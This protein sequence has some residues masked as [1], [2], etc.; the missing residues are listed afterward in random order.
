M[1]WF[2]HPSDLAR[3]EDVSQYLDAAGKDR[4]S[5]YGFL[6]FLLEAIASRM[7]AKDGH[8]VCSAKYSI[9]QWGRITFSHPNRVTKYLQLCKVIQWVVVEFDEGSCKVSIPK[10]VEWRDE[11]TRKSGIL[12]E[13]FAQSRTDKEREDESESTNDNSLSDGSTRSNASRT[14]PQDFEI[15]PELRKWAED[16]RPDVDIDRET[17]KFLVHEFSQPKAD[18][19]AA[20]KKWILDARPNISAGSTGK[21]S[22]NSKS[23]LMEMAPLL[24]IDRKDDESE[25]EFLARVKTANDERIAHLAS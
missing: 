1:K 11:T 9:P 4:V 8:L 12:P 20:W 16:K 21:N 18:W 7:S 23:D 3:D 22:N 24:G 15:T 10:M 14:A 6:M 25:E 17:E 13:Q 2:K 19:I 5:A